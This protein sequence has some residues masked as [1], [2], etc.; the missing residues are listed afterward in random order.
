M[1]K[2]S[3]NKVRLSLAVPALP[4]R[5]FHGGRKGKVACFDF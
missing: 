4:L 1:N 3:F 5:Y 2:V